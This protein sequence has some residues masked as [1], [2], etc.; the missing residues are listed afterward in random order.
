MNPALLPLLMLESPAAEFSVSKGHRENVMPP[1]AC[2][3]VCPTFLFCEDRIEW[4]RTQVRSVQVHT[5]RE[6]Y[7]EEQGDACFWEEC[8]ES[9]NAWGQKKCKNRKAT[10]LSHFFCFLQ[11]PSLCSCTTMTTTQH[12]HVSSATQKKDENV[13]LSH[14][15]VAVKLQMI[16]CYSRNHLVKDTGFNLSV[17]HNSY[18]SVLRQL[19]S[20][21]AGALDQIIKISEMSCGKKKLQGK[22]I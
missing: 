17:S 21:S 7:V 18:W 19:L 2:G 16:K 5:S 20:H 4:K 3:R 1:T 11:S 9:T 14:W 15:T 10:W 13:G 12:P 6:G 8:E 22:R